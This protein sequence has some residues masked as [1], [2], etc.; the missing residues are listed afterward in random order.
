VFARLTRAAEP[1]RIYW[2][3]YGGIRALAGS[4]YLWSAIALTIACYPLW[5]PFERAGRPTAQL[6]I[7]IVPSLMAFSL[8]GMA[9]LLAFSGGRFLDAIRQRGAPNSLFMEIVA[10]FFHFLLMQSAA[11]VL[12]VLVKAYP[13]GWALAG[14]AFFFLAYSLTSAIASSAMLLNAS[15]IFNVVG[16]DDDRTP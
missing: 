2:R 6:A 13:T 14:V 8:G 10:N 15:R 9:I 4:L 1:F 12:A 3:N 16:G 5:R 11:L 7:D